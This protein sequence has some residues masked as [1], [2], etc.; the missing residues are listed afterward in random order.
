MALSRFLSPDLLVFF[1]Y[2]ENSDFFSFPSV[3]EQS[4][5]FLLSPFD[6]N[7]KNVLMSSLLQILC[8]NLLSPIF[9]KK[10]P[11]YRHDRLLSVL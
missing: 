10:L 3:T 2:R 1:R 11:V 5:I 8:N 6:P 9:R 7:D 4:F